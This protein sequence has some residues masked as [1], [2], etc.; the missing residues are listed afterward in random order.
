MNTE[1]F[2]ESWNLSCIS[3]RSSLPISA[4]M[5]NISACSAKNLV[6]HHF[7]WRTWPG[8]GQDSAAFCGGAPG[9]ALSSLACS[10]R[11]ASLDLS[12]WLGSGYSAGSLTSIGPNVSLSH[13]KIEQ[14]THVLS[15]HSSYDC[16]ETSLRSSVSPNT[17]EKHANCNLWTLHA[18]G[19]PRKVYLSTR[20]FSCAWLSSFHSRSM[21]CAYS[22]GIQKSGFSLD[23]SESDHVVIVQ[24]FAIYVIRC[25]AS[26]WTS[27]SSVLIGC[28]KLFTVEYN[29]S[30]PGFAITVS[31][32][33]SSGAPEH[34]H[35]IRK[36]L[37]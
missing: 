17:N 8:R 33:G 24:G 6:S 7:K 23:S 22:F 19:A 30:A 28:I 20:V 10:G 36:Q 21:R 9:S 3:V 35:I 11:S 34:S 27:S 15:G 32:S 12:S 31:S 37:S 2:R 14:S 25:A 5:W 29:A 16:P 4:Y 1:G 13:P 26:C 18:P